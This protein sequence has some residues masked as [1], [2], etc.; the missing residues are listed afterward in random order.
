MSSN[1][2]V[3]KFSDGGKREGMLM[4]YIKQ[5]RRSSITECRDLREVEKEWSKLTAKWCR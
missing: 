4:R 5:P 3:G 2:L 1:S